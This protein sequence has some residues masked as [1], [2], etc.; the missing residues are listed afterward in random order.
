MGLWDRLHAAAAP[1]R[2][3][4]LAHPVVR[5]IG[6]GSLPL[7][8][9]QYYLRQ[10]Y[11]FLIEYSRVLALASARATDL[12][13]AEKFAELLHLTLTVEMD[14]HRRVC[15]SAG[16]SRNEL[17]ATRP[18]P[19]TTAYTRHLRLVAET[20]DLSAIVASILPCAHGYW[21]IASSLQD[22]G[23]PLHQPL[24]ADWIRLYTSEEYA[25]MARWLV[26]VLDR[27]G[28]GVPPSREA[29][30]RELHLLSA[31]YEYLFWEMAFRGEEWPL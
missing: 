23:L 11:V 13:V 10:D 31:R 22:R 17:E 5:G 15:G 7:E 14:L 9:Y 19:T 20:E 16:I 25:A 12:A 30:L 4:I 18:A 26:H 8:T 28:E 24:Y 29:V 1:I 6:D 3:R 27:L 2:E 21:E